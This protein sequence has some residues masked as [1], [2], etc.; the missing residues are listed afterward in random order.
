MLCFINLNQIFHTVYDATYLYQIYNR[1][2]MKTCKMDVLSLIY[3]FS[4]EAEIII[5]VGQKL[6]NIMLCT[7]PKRLNKK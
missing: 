5:L 7:K 1:M 4:E 6:D 2:C 3:K